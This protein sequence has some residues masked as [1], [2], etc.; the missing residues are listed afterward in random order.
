[1]ISRASLIK[2]TVF[3]LT[4]VL[5]VN[6]SQATAVH[7]DT[8]GRLTIVVTTVNGEPVTG[9]WIR[10]TGPELVARSPIQGLILKALPISILILAPMMS[11]W[12]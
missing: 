11:N 7:A 12:I 6:L 8:T 4:V 1:M 10:C 2:A 5:I 3:V 9:K